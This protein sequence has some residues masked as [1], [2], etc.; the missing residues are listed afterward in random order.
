MDVRLANKQLSDGLFH[1]LISFSYS[2]V[3]QLSR[4]LFLHKNTLIM[5]LKYGNIFKIWESCKKRELS[6]Y[7]NVSFVIIGTLNNLILGSLKKDCSYI[8]FK[9]LN[10]FTN[11]NHAVTVI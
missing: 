9:P 3:Y 2:A 10:F 4:I 8:I 6:N 1:N 7:N 11:L 5:L